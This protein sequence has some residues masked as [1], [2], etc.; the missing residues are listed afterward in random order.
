MVSIEFE[1]S[2]NINEV[3]HSF[4]NLDLVKCL[5]IVVDTMDNLNLE[6]ISKI[7]FSTVE[8]HLKI[9]FFRQTNYS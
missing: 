5:T 6:F 2:P 3:A 9:N 7:Y 8:L 4:Y 1:F